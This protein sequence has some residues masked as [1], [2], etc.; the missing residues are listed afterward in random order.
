MNKLNSTATVY[1]QVGISSWEY[2]WQLCFYCF[3]WHGK[4]IIQFR[5]LCVKLAFDGSQT[6]NSFTFSPRHQGRDCFLCHVFCFY[7]SSSIGALL[8][9]PQRCQIPRLVL[10][11]LISHSKELGVVTSLIEEMASSYLLTTESLLKL[12]SLLD[13]RVSS[14]PKKCLREL[15]LKFRIICSEGCRVFIDQLSLIQ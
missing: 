3:S 15:G 11:W 13:C 6:S 9:G 5:K 14:A 7:L 4:N 8:Y 10:V 1:K 12:N 2:R